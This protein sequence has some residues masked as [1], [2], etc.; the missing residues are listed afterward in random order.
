MIR[1]YF[2]QIVMGKF[3]KRK[4]MKFLNT[5]ELYA[6]G[7]PALNFC[8]LD[9]SRKIQADQFRLKKPSKNEQLLPPNM[10]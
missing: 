2:L 1:S 4:L 9:K 7:I 6:K 3:I 5:V 8:K 10:E